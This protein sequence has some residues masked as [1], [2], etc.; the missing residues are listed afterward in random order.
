ME[1]LPSGQG[2]GLGFCYGS[3]GPPTPTVSIQ[4]PCEGKKRVCPPWAS[5]YHPAIVHSSLSVQESMNGVSLL[6]GAFHGQAG[7]G[8][9][10]P[11]G[12][13]AVSSHELALRPGLFRVSPLLGWSINKKKGN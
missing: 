1:A 4:G 6:C 5:S 2:L 10:L 12:A 3:S 9:S 8:K 11:L 13:A 7:C